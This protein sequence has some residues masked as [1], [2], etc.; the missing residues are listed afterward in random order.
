MFAQGYQKIVPDSW[1]LIND[2]DLI[3]RWGKLLALCK[4]TCAQ[5]FSIRALQTADR[6]VLADKRPGKR[7][8]INRYGKRPTCS[9]CSIAAAA[10]A[11][12]CL[13]AQTL[14]AEGA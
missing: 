2:Q 11:W 4:R 7:V 12:L 1:D 3:S 9:L 10:K 5:D 6:P 8:T 13:A 14:L